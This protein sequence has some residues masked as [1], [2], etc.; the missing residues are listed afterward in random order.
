LCL[1]TNKKKSKNMLH[2]QIACAEI[3]LRVV[4]SLRED[5][6]DEELPLVDDA[7]AVLG[8]V[9]VTV[10]AVEAMRRLGACPDCRPG[11]TNRSRKAMFMFFSPSPPGLPRSFIHCA[12]GVIWVLH[13]ATMLLRV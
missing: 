7:G 9:F 10:T 4:L 8:S 1:T 5:L 2:S 6:L 13:R 12:L 3:N 11:C